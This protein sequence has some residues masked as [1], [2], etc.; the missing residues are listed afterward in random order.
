V[1]DKFQTIRLT[2]RGFH[3]GEDF[4]GEIAGI[5]DELLAEADE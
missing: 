4:E 3:E 1:I 2:K 5:V